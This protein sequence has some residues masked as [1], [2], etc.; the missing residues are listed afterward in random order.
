MLVFE[1]AAKNEQAQKHGGQQERKWYCTT[2]LRHASCSCLIDHE[3]WIAVKVCRDAAILR[4]IQLEAFRANEALV[5]ADRFRILIFLRAVL[6]TLSAK[7]ERIVFDAGF[8][9]ANRS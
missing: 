7:I 8:T 1:I 9:R 4:L 5:N 6:D 2:R 3:A